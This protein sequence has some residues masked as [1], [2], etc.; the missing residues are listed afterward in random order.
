M[1]LK[2]DKTDFFVDSWVNPVCI[3]FVVYNEVMDN[4][5][6]GRQCKYLQNAISLILQKKIDYDFLY[7]LFYFR[8]LRSKC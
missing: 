3:Y 7:F 6:R 4:I 1:H 2:K 8:Y 5:K